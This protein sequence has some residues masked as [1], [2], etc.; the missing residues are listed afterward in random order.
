MK[1][2]KYINHIH[3]SYA[4][5]ILAHFLKMEMEWNPNTTVDFFSCTSF[6]GGCTPQSLPASTAAV[7]SAARGPGSPEKGSS[8]KQLKE[9]PNE[10]PVEHRVPLL[11]IM[12]V[13]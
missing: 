1:V 11:Y 4:L 12:D 3:G 10:P 8:N 2:S 6:G 9:L 7:V 13:S 5:G